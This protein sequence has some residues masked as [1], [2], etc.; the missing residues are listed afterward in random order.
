MSKAKKA[1][2]NIKDFATGCDGD[3][4]GLSTCTLDLDESGD[5]RFWGELRLGVKREYEGKVRGGYAGF[6]NKVRSL[7]GDLGASSG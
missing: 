7:S 2:L 6:R 1:D 3:I 5:A 4:G